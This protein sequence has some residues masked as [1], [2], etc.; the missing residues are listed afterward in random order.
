MRLTNCLYL[1]TMLPLAACAADA[2]T[3]E[4]TPAE[5]Q[6]GWDSQAGNP[7]HATHSYLTEYAVDQ[8]KAQ[9]PELATYKTTIVNGANTE[10]HE[11]PVTD[12]DLESLRVAAD[13][14]NWAANHPEVIWHKAQDAYRAG[15]KDRAYFLTGIVLHWVEDMG[16]PAHAFHVIHQGTFSLRD[17][18]ELLAL[19]K[20]APLY[21]SIN[22]SDPAYTAPSDYMSFSGVWAS[23]DFQAAWPGVTYTRSFFSSSWLWASNKEATFVENRQGRTATLTKWALYAAVTHF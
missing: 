9:F 11:L 17:N 10:L 12:P 3:P 14:T 6:D 16:V 23:T 22:H 21:S 7:T 2:Q 15:N 4:P 5:T 8:L 1:L 19:Q 13:G 20:W 18:F